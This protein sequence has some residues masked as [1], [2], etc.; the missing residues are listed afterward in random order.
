MEVP[1][2][3]SI[4]KRLS[5]KMEKMRVVE[6]CRFANMVLFIFQNSSFCQVH[7]LV[8]N[9]PKEVIELARIGPKFPNEVQTW[10]LLRY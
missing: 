1:E 6:K 2:G 9:S 7:F 3:L 8:L 4:I 10:R 5:Q